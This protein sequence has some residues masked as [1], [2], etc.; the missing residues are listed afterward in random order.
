MNFIVIFVLLS[1]LSILSD[2]VI[3]FAKLQFGGCIGAEGSG[4]GVSRYPG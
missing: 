1:K 2:E 4:L 3:C